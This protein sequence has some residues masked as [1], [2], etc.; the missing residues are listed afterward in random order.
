[1][2]NRTFSPPPTPTPALASPLPAFVPAALRELPYPKLATAIFAGYLFILSS[3]IV[4]IMIAYLGVRF[5]LVAGAFLVLLATYVLSGNQARFMRSPF[6]VPWIM[7]WVWWTAAAVLG[8]YPKRSVAYMLLFGLRIQ[9]LPFIFCSLA[10]TMPA[11]RRVASGFSAG[12]IVIMLM[13]YLFGTT[14]NNRF[15]V[16]ETTLANGNDLALHIVLG[17]C[18]I[19]ITLMRGSA[20]A[21]LTCLTSLPV[22]VYYVLKTGSR[23]NLLTLGLWLIVALFTLPA[24]WRV[25]ILVTGPII[26]VAV[27][28]MLP[29]GTATRLFTFA[30]A[31]RLEDARESELAQHA[32]DSTNA[33]LAL[34][35]R[36]IELTLRHP[37]F[38]VG[39]LMF[40]DAVDE[41]VR[42]AEGRRSTWQVSH[43]SYLQIS[44]ETGIPGFLLYAWCIFQC[45][46]MNYK[47]YRL[48]QRLGDMP[49]ASAVSFC[50]LLASVTYAFGILF[51]SIALDYYLAAL[52]G[53][54]AAS[55]LAIED[56]LRR[57]QFG[58]I[59]PVLPWLQK[60]IARAQA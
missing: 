31:D 59:Q 21:R 42:N 60:P 24:R 22:I 53:F 10:L 34:Q 57:R 13:C 48:T 14:V 52:V 4:Q 54:T 1:M 50:L 20:L 36:A 12:Y 33:R 58:D 45:L 43:N 5:P 26:L 29:A 55:S 7:M 35:R 19:M 44:S 3:I 39:P 30:N 27:I 17:A 15:F 38:G 2:R 47:S 25:A 8:V 32:V 9:I 56:E 40:E 51:C 6:F 18:F 37:L 49:D 11:I 23:S 28:S 46:R 16:P 41:Y